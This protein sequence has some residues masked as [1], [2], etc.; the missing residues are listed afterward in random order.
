ML[1]G[2]EAVSRADTSQECSTCRYK[3]DIER[4]QEDITR[5]RDEIAELKE[6][7]RTLRQQ[8]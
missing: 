4:Y 2:L 6:E 5:Y 8:D 7:L 1:R 3:Q